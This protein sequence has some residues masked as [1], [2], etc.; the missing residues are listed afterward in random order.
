MKHYTP[1]GWIDQPG[2][3]IG[4]A[5]GTEEDYDRLI[6]EWE[7]KPAEFVSQVVYALTWNLKSA[8]AIITGIYCDQ[9]CA[10]AAEGAPFERG[11]LFPQTGETGKVVTWIQCDAVEHGFAATWYAMIEHFGEDDKQ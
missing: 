10:V 2:D 8:A 6:N 4:P 7:A 1:A 9:W 3:A 5:W 11:G